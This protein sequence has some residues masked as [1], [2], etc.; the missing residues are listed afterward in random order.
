MHGSTRG[1][2]HGWPST[3]TEVVLEP[4]EDERCCPVCS[5]RMSICDHRFRRI[6]T[7]SGPVR[8]CC[9]L[10]QC[11]DPCCRSGRKTFSPKSEQFIAPP[12]LALDW[13][14]F[15][16]IGH[17]RF[18]RHWS[19]PTICAELTD[20]FEI[21]F[22]PDAIA[23]YIHRYEC[24]VAA[25][26]QDP[27]QLVDAYANIPDVVLS[28][29]GLQPEQGHE[30][31]YVVRELNAGRVWFAVP[32]LS[33][34]APE[35]EALLERA[36]AIAASLGKPVRAWVSDKQQAFVTGIA[37]VFPD[38]PHRLCKIHFVR[39][40]AKETRDEDG[41][42]KVQ[43]RKKVRG[44]RAIER[45]VL[46]VVR[47]PPG[48]RPEAAFAGLPT[49]HLT[50]TETSDSTDVVTT[51]REEPTLDSKEST[52]YET[53]AAPGAE[54]VSNAS[55][56]E[57]AD[58]VQSPLWTDLVLDYCAVTRGILNDDQGTTLDPSGLRMARALE[59]VKVSLDVCKDAQKGGPP[60]A[61]WAP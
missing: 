28:I 61:A 39:R 21:V 43:M 20:R 44:L 48:E 27:A 16:W 14:L 58:C 31:L 1:M 54:P 7:T 38:V 11:P 37:K 32:L 4:E 51:S 12:K 17:R 15:A 13:E 6:E 2:S 19:V 52:S 23:Q 22:S 33:S 50:F 40:L 47:M 56:G 9:K 25:R 60:K 5:R 24:M 35:I 42:V 53:A 26:H 3:F 34:T 30:V 46:D 41:R 59:E 18:A 55:T 45:A 10:V 57:V 29:D 36:R 8:L 49:S